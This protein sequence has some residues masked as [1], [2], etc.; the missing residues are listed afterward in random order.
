MKKRFGSY[1]FAW[2]RLYIYIY[3]YTVR[4]SWKDGWFAYTK[5]MRRR[6]HVPH[7]QKVEAVVRV[8]FFG[9]LKHAIHPTRS[10]AQ[11]LVVTVTGLGDNPMYSVSL[12]FW[13]VRLHMPNTP[14]TEKTHV[15]I[16]LPW[17][18]P[19][20][21]LTLPK[22]NSKNPWK[23]TFQPNRKPDRLPVASWLSGVNS[24]LN[25]GCVCE[26]WKKPWLFVVYWG[27]NP[28]QLLG[29]Y[30]INHYKDPY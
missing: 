29:D 7:V 26:Q 19:V 18:I 28:T 16:K 25:L 1:L 22:F 8:N 30:F 6:T 9:T 13:G 14:Y 21:G 17:W 5:W 23:V 4:N 24:L 15:T 2:T 27:W 10:V 20:R 3:I 11:L 12:A